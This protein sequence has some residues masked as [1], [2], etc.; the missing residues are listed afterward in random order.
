MRIHVNIKGSSDHN[1]D[2]ILYD[3]DDED[4][5]EVDGVGATGATIS[6]TLVPSAKF[7]ITSTV[8]QLLNLKGFLYSCS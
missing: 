4:D 5:V 8:I 2:S 1:S 3:I 6:P 7:Y